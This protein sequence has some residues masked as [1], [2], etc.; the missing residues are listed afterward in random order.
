MRFQESVRK[1]KGGLALI[2][3]GLTICGL[4][5]MSSVC[6]AGGDK[7]TKKADMPTARDSLSTSVVGGKIYAI[8]GWPPDAGIKTVE[9]YD[10]VKDT[11]TKKADMP[12]AR[13]I[14][15][16][17]VVDGRIY[18]IGGADFAAGKT[19]PVVEEYNPT[20]DMWTRKA[21]MPTSRQSL[22][23]SVVN[24]QIYAI[25]GASFADRFA[26]SLSTVEVYDPVTD[27]WTKKADMPTVR[28]GLSTIRY[29]RQ[30][31]ARSSV[32]SSFNNRGI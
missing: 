9:E 22:S 32:E 27:K 10:P 23:T 7:W 29:W 25:G 18:T 16:T 21:D 20:T 19:F 1:V 4:F 17:S 14:F 12:T 13:C 24:G 2:L 15:S 5:I 31:C 3:A 6:L 26:P 8:G 28:D 11:W 30:A